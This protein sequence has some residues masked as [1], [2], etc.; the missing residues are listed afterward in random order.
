MVRRLVVGLV[1]IIVFAGSLLTVAAQDAKKDGGKE[2]KAKDSKGIKAKISKVDIDK[3]TI[4][5]ETEDG[6]KHDFKVD[7]DVK[8]IGPNGG[9][10][11][12]GIKDDRVKAGAQVTLVTDASGKTLKEV[13]LPRRG[14][15]GGK[16]KDK[17]DK[18]PSKDA[19]AKDK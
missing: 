7:D 3:M 12:Q 6:K 9:L 10:S 4:S 19:P 8:F 17:I 1:G 13:H 16:G 11:K 15:G 18:A 14:G 5:V 2:T